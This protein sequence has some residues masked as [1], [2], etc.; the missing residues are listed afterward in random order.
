MGISGQQQQQQQAD[1]DDDDDDEPGSSHEGGTAGAK[2]RRRQRNMKQQELNRLAQQRY[3]SVP[4]TVWLH[5]HVR[6]RQAG[7][8][9]LGERPVGRGL[10]RTS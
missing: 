7:R 2:R 6:A 3:R 4:G 9:L 1:D 5:T 8:Q 10:T